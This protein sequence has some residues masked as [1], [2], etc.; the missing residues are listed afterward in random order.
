MGKKPERGEI[1]LSESPSGKEIEETK[2]R[3]KKRRDFLKEERIRWEERTK[4]IP[5]KRFVT[6]AKRSAQFASIMYYY[7]TDIYGLL[8]AIFSELMP[9][10]EKTDIKTSELSEQV[11]K[12]SEE[13]EKH[14]PIVERMEEAFKATNR[15]FEEGR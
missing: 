5:E 4:T 7:L 3:L 11:K 10:M 6:R 9:I 1:A 14:K 12:L 13:L 15:V 2:K 8:E